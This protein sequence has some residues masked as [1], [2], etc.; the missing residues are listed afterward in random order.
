MTRVT[1]KSA[2]DGSKPAR[3]AIDRFGAMAS[4]ACALHC[5]LGPSL[6][7]VLGALGLGALLGHGT[8]WAF[9][10]LALVFAATALFLGWRRHRSVRVIS[11]LGAGVTALLLARLLEHALDEAAGAVLSVLA[12]LTLVVGHVSNIRASRHVHLEGV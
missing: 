8:E 7:G 1:P 6:P 10:L 5:L 9:T 3:Q 11:M 2:A 12:G 4:T